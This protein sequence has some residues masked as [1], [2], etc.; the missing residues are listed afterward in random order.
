MKLV[1]NVGVTS[2]LF[3]KRFQQRPSQPSSSV[4][5]Y[6]NAVAMSM[7]KSNNR[8]EVFFSTNARQDV[9]LKVL[10]NIVMAALEMP[11]FHSRA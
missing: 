1:H 5:R 8:N 2:T 10:R 11:L 6:P 4:P 3:V 7:H 9:R